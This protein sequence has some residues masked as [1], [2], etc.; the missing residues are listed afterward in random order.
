VL[1]LLGDMAPE[2]SDPARFVRFI[3]NR[4]V[5]ENATVRAAAT[6]T[7]AAICA[8][9]ELLRDR[10][11]T[12]LKRSL[13]DNDDEVRD[14]CTLYLAHLEGRAGSPEL[15]KASIDVPLANLERDL[16][17]YLAG[18]MDADFDI[19][20]VDRVVEEVIATPCAAGFCFCIL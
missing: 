9:C 6:A 16:Q 13:A 4:I 14:R 15:I 11:I 17:A 5:L 19:D 7:L 12:I 20:S 18:P 3:Y 2:T 1:H 10:T 8:R